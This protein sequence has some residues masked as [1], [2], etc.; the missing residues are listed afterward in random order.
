VRAGRAAIE[1]VI[2][3]EEERFDIVLSGGLPKLEEALEEAAA[4]NKQ[5]PG[6]LAFRLYDTFGLPLD[7]IEDLAG[8]RHVGVDRGGFEKAMEAQREKGRAKSAFEGRKVEDFT[9]A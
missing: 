5:V 1:Q 7:F 4:G 3:S 8:E 2:Q 6:D 9:Y